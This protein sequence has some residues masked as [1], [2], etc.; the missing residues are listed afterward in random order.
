[1]AGV[2]KQIEEVGG[3]RPGIGMDTGSSTVIGVRPCTSTKWGPRTSAAAATLP[4][5]PEKP[6]KEDDEVDLYYI[7]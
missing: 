5:P 4:W 2:A 3:V 7:P 6:G 1:M